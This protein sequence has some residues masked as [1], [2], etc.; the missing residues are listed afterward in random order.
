MKE[1]RYK[2]EDMFRTVLADYPNLLAGD[3]RKKLSQMAHLV[4][5]SQLTT[6]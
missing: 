5:N 4:R 3:Q 2:S 1:E 6:T